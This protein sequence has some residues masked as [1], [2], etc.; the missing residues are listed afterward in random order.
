MTLFALA[1]MGPAIT[2]LLWV[3]I[4]VTAYGAAYLFVHEVYIHRR[5]PVRLPARR[6]PRLAARRPPGPPPLRGEPYG[7]LLPLVSGERRRAA[8]D[9][10]PAG[11]DPLARARDRARPRAAAPAPPGC[12]CSAERR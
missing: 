4:G 5:L 3:A 8:R 6:L 2:P 7:M 1:T 9:S 11:R 10:A 12:G